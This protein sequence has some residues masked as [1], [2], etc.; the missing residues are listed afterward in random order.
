MAHFAPLR[1]FKEVHQVV[2]GAEALELDVGHLKAADDRLLRLQ[3][4]FDAAVRHIHAGGSGQV[5]DAGKAGPLVL[6]L[7]LAGAVFNTTCFGAIVR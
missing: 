5:T 3:V 6:A 4:G 1:G 7:I 2:V